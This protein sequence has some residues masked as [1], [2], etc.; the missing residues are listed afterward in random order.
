MVILRSQGIEVR[1]DGAITA[2]PT[3]RNQVTTTTVFGS[4]K[5]ESVRGVINISVRVECITEDDYDKLITLFLVAN[6]RV[7]VEDM[8]RGKFYSNYY[9]TGESIQFE[10]KEDV[11]NNAY[12]YV[13]GMNLN[14][15]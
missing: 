10:E 15:R 14:K 1:I 11:K 12:Y 7:D 13:G 9:I 5:T 6:N 2:I 8:D 3:V 4:E